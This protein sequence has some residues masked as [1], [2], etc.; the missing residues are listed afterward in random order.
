MLFVTALGGCT[1]DGASVDIDGKDIDAVFIHTSDM[2][3]RLIPYTMDVLTMDKNH[4]MQQQ[5]GP[6]GG[7]ARLSAVLKQERRNHP[8]VA[9][10]DTGDVFQGAPIFNAFMG[11]IEFKA[12]TQLRVDAFTI[13][14]H[15]FDNGAHAMVK[16]AVQYANFPMLGGNYSLGDWRRAGITPNGRIAEPYTILNLKGLR[17]GVIGL[18]SMGGSYGANVKGLVPLNNR[19]VAQQYVDFLRPIVD[20]VVVTSH[21]GYHED[22]YII[23]RTEGIDLYFGGHLHIALNPPEVV[24]DCD[25]TKLERERDL[26]KCDTPEK[27]KAA[28]KAC[29]ELMGC[30]NLKG[31][32]LT[33]CQQ[34]CV[35][36]AKQNCAREAEVRN[37]KGKLEQLEDDIAFLKQR[38]CHPRDVI[39][40]HS[41]AFLKYFGKLEVNLRQCHRLEQKSVCLKRDASGKCTDSRARSCRGNKG[42][43]NDWEVLAH[44]YTL[45]PVDNRLPDDPQMVDLLEPYTLELNRQQQLTEVIG[46]AAERVQRFATYT[47][48]SDQAG[49]QKVG[50]ANKGDSPLGNLVCDAMLRREQVWADF[51]IT[52][53]L[54]MRS[55]IVSGPVDSE[56]MN[57]VFPFE[58]SITVL[59]LSGYEVQE[60]MDFVAQ[61]SASRGCQ[62]QAQVSGI[63]ATLNCKGCTDLG[64]NSCVRRTYDGEACAQRVTVGG[65]GRA[66]STDADCVKDERG[67]LTGEICSTADH[68]DPAKAGKKR[69]FAPLSCTRSY[70]LATNDYIAHGGSGFQVLARNTS[71]KNLKIPLRDTAK[72]FIANMP[73]CSRVPLSYAE[74]VAGKSPRN[75]ITEVLDAAL[76]TI[77]P[78]GQPKNGTEWMKQ[79]EK[80]AVGGDWK[81]ADGQFAKMVTALKAGLNKYKNPGD[82]LR[83]GLINYLACID[84]K[85]DSKTGKCLGLACLQKQYCNVYKVKELAKCQALGRIR[86][87]LRCINLPCIS[88]KQ[89][90]RI[91]LIKDEGAGS[92]NPSDPFPE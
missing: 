87:A 45:T 71:Q 63:T 49:G 41:G 91:N 42:V 30:A 19:K 25:I 31:T 39:L 89:D 57:N 32:E 54:G 5:Y 66:C 10:I 65:S 46:F 53:S 15:E 40:T 44:R 51:S 13:G 82:P 47:D 27:L 17:V 48:T 74:Q 52:N 79:M 78:P 21:V 23:S 18:A 20:L 2:H 56:Q 83:K 37:Y 1:L 36:Q 50:A 35:A 75:V 4:G 11:E 55:D 68:P 38:K 85:P 6:F 92:V 81:G 69:C 24:K 88:A 33:K 9:Y 86:A 58:N 29:G 77:K 26:Y 59:Y 67:Q 3:S 90:G 28:E 22:R 43:T 76:P 7:M 8:R 64:G 70:R 73:G 12:L 61:R 80:A 16:K 60:M 72:D 34:K 14:N 84:E 62:P